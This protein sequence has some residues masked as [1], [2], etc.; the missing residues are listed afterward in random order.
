MSMLTD[1]DRTTQ[2]LTEMENRQ[3]LGRRAFI[4]GAAAT[5]TAA[6]FAGM[7]RPLAIARAAT[8]RGGG[9]PPTVRI[10]HFATDG[11]R[12]GTDEVPT[13][14]KSDDAW[15]A[16]LSTRSYEVTRHS[17]TEMPFTGPLTQEH[18]R[19]IF[20]CICCDTAL[21]ASET[22]FDSGTGWPS[23]YQAIAKENVREDHDRTMGME[24]VAV[25]CSRCDA[26]L[27]HVFDDGPAPT[28]LRYC[29]N[30]ASLRFASLA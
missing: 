1:A 27:G 3:P 18:R 5:A 26:H 19:G 30:S 11:K 13:V 22:K 15:R 6:L 23:F 20:S 2:P 4:L 14:Q 25:A 10:V 24:R 16:Q 12:L 29:M 7:H 28:G 21:F 9:L 8:L 17:D